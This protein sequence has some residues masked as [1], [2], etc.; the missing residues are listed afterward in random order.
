MGLEKILDL[1]PQEGKKNV[2][3]LQAWK[4]R[5]SVL[6][7]L[8]WFGLKVVYGARGEGPR[9]LKG[10]AVIVFDKHGSSIDAVMPTYFKSYIAMIARQDRTLFSWVAHYGGGPTFNETEGPRPSFM[11]RIVVHLGNGSVIGLFPYSDVHNGTLSYGVLDHLLKWE[12]KHNEQ[13]DFR[14]AAIVWRQTIKDSPAR[15]WP[16]YWPPF[17]CF[18]SAILVS[19]EPIWSS[20]LPSGQRNSQGLLTASQRESARLRQEYLQRQQ[21]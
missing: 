16:S 8:M 5:H 2:E 12:G 15:V 7:G 19:D 20:C 6:H 13:I 4:S 11:K 14:A 9:E 1:F 17:F 18:S 21:K 3:M 10:P